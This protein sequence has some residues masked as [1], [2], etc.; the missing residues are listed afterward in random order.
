MRRE[1]VL[2]V[3]GKRHLKPLDLTR[4]FSD[5]KFFRWNYTGP[6]QNSPVWVVGA[7]GKARTKGRSRSRCVQ[8]LA[9]PAQPKHHGGRRDGERHRFPSVLHRRG[10]A[11][12]HRML[13]SVAGRRVFATFHG[14]FMAHLGTNMSSWWW[15]EDN[16][17]SHTKAFFSSATSSSLRG[18]RARQT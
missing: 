3:R 4:V 5:E 11:H 15:Q 12:Q 1:G 8:Q 6:A 14:H 18:L 17:P 10:C 9:Q 16:A 13:H 2:S 7:H